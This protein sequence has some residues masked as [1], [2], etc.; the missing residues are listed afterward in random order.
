MLRTLHRRFADTARSH[1]DRTALELGPTALSYRELYDLVERTAK[2]IADTVGSDKPR[3]ALYATREVST[4]VAYLAIQQVRGTAI[5]LNPSAPNPRNRH[6]VEAARACAVLSST[7][8][9]SNLG[10]PQLLISPGHTAIGTLSDGDPD[11][12]AYILFTSGSTGAPKGVPITQANVDAYLKRVCGRYEFQPGMR[13]SQTFDLTF[14]LSV[15]DMFAAWSTGATLVVPSRTELM[16][17]VRFAR[18]KGL[19]HWFSVPSIVSYAH[20]LRSLSPNSL[21]ELR[22]TLFCGEPLTLQQAR[23]WHTA[24][25]S[26]IIE[27]LYGPTELT[28][29]CAE[30]RLPE[31]T[32]DWPETPNGTVPI[33]AIYPHLHH[34][35][36]NDNGTPSTEGELLVRGSQRFGGYT[37]A[38]DD[39]GQFSRMSSNRL[40]P[41][42]TD[43]RPLPDDWYHTG[44]RVT[45]L[46]GQLV[47]L[48]RLDSQV[49]IRGY[50][51]ELGEVEAAL[52]RQPGVHDAIVVATSTNGDQ[53]LEAACTG[54][55]LDSD[56]LL[57]ALRSALPKYM[58]PR[59]VVIRDSLP[60]NANGKIDRSAIA[61]TMSNTSL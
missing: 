1:P 25:P 59:R 42:S 11:D 37:N 2:Q 18:E 6:I 19:T 55:G 30:Y 35:I 61:R 23:R 33:G 40:V 57:A 24:A 56:T 38:S 39:A 14:D 12:L 52:R 47:H 36:V 21:P 27:N 53:I 9:S 51:V 15:F 31:Q 41:S 4:Y 50:R 48:G 20:R 28:I 34:L 60:L 32:D 44:D 45:E 58:V 7:D 29:S 54:T 46:G 3:L 8:I 5:P 43:C 49:K 22:W 10:A 17:P 16:A 26:A 13:A